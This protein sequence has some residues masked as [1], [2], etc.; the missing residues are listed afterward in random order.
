MRPLFRAS[1]AFL[2][3]SAAVTPLFTFRMAVQS[4]WTHQLASWVTCTLGRFRFTFQKSIWRKFRRQKPRFALLLINLTLARSHPCS[5]FEKKKVALLLGNPALAF[6]HSFL[7]N[8]G[9]GLAR[10]EF[11]VSSWIKAH[12]KALLH[13]ELLSATDRK[14]IQTVIGPGTPSNWTAETG[15]A[16]FVSRLSAGIAILA[17]AFYPKPCILRFS[18][19][20]TD[21]YEF[22]I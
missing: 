10:M 17:A 6:S 11:L 2:A 21:E 5:H 20:K 3:W 16:H 13:P 19:F 9:C 1:L 4:R 8:D 12:P 15:R 18:D 22:L 7:P 14:E